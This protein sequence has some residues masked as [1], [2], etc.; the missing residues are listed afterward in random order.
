MQQTQVQNLRQSIP[1]LAKPRVPMGGYQLVGGDQQSFDIMFRAFNGDWIE[2]LEL[3]RV[4]GKWMR[5]LLVE[6]EQKVRPYFWRI[7]TDYPRVNG[8][9]DVFWPKP[10]KG[11]PVWER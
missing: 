4:N 1:D 9:L 2:R 11:K 6:T 10:V 3:R 7:D 8:H 5:A